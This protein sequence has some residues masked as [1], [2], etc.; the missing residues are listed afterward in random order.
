MAGYIYFVFLMIF[1]VIPY[2]QFM[3]ISYS[4]LS[5]IC[6]VCTVAQAQDKTVLDSLNKV[7]AKAKHD[8]T[9][10][11]VLNEISQE[12]IN[13][14]PDTVWLFAKEMQQLSEKSSFKRGQV[15]SCSLQGIVYFIQGKKKESIQTLQKGIR[16]AETSP[17]KKNLALPIYGTLGNIYFI[18]G[19]HPLALEYMQKTLKGYEI[20]GNEQGMAVLLSNMG[21]LYFTEKEY[22]KALKFYQKSLKLHQKFQDTQGIV[23]AL[24]GIG[25]SYNKLEKF[26][27][28]L[29]YYQTALDKANSLSE[30]RQAQMKALIGFAHLGKNDYAQAQKYFEESLKVQRDKSLPVQLFNNLD[31]LAQ[32]HIKIKNYPKAIQYAEEGLSIAQKYQ[33]LF[34]VQEFSKHLS[35][36]HKA[37]NSFEKA[38]EY[39]ELF[40]QTTDSLFSVEKSKA[41]ANLEAK[42]EIEN[43]EKEIKI[44]NQ[45]QKFLKKEKELQQY[46]LYV[47]LAGLASVLVFAYFTFRSRQK[48]RKTNKLVSKQKGEIQQI[49]E[50][51]IFS[52]K[53]LNQ[54]SQELKTLNDAKDK[55]FA[56]IG[57]DLR[58]PVNSLYGLLSLLKDNTISQEQ[59]LQLSNSL[60]I[61]VA[62]LY[63][64]LNN[65]LQW[66]Y[67][68]MRGLSTDPTKFD[69]SKVEDAV[70]ELFVEVA[71]SKSIT[72][73][74]L[75][76]EDTLVFADKDQ[77]TL[78]FRNIIN[79]ALKFTP[80]NG[81]IT[82]SSQEEAD[83]YQM[84]VQDNGLGISP[85]TLE[86]LFQDAPMSSKRGTNNETGTGLGLMLCKDFIQK[87]GG[88]IWAE[89]EEQKG[90]SFYFTLPKGEN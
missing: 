20:L 47:V 68:Q 84:K 72:L 14:N 71:K 16:I 7:Q 33:H 55:I 18:E 54:Q 1:A 32:L 28:A 74:N 38:L 42:V 67:N 76:P 89:S 48:E 79:N 36:A 2:K 73:K 88:Q 10:V 35:I 66:A 70:G 41:I 25:V 45:K 64:T 81:E 69:V 26:D 86:K 46:I 59:F 22:Q 13:H 37:Q 80:K 30:A 87:N 51:L 39:H 63:F 40:Q 75:I 52:N 60:Q 61:G 82:I 3:K 5:A 17:Q 50:E 23:H 53:T 58:S 31:G 9:K 78:V 90:S 27:T 11:L 56:I 57:H 77:I 21:H 12:Y 85:E 6:L 4:L 15:L 29:H 43:K 44:L 83:F 8:T 62:G 24:E 34:F 65:L 49:N 19:N